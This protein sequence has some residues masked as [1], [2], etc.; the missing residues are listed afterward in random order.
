MVSTTGAPTRAGPPLTSP[1]TAM[2]PPTAWARASSPGL[3][4]HGPSGPK[5]DT[6][7]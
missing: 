4:R 2:S 5:A 3:S 6:E 1:V 7:Q